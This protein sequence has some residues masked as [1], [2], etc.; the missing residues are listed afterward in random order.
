MMMTDSLLL[1]F[2][3]KSLDEYGIIDYCEVN[4]Q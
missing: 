1:L 4:V 2:N 3:D